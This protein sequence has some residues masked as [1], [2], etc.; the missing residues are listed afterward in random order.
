MIS[1]QNSKIL[2]PPPGR[3][4]LSCI[5][6]RQLHALVMRLQ[7]NTL[8]GGRGS[9]LLSRSLVCMLLSPNRLNIETV[10]ELINAPCVVWL[11]SRGPCVLSYIHE[12]SVLIPWHVFGLP[13]LSSPLVSLFIWILISCWIITVATGVLWF[14]FIINIQHPHNS[15]WSAIQEANT[16]AHNQTN[17]SVLCL[18]DS[19][20]VIISP[21][22]SAEQQLVLTF[23]LLISGREKKKKGNRTNRVGRITRC[24]NI[25][26]PA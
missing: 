14:F 21:Q 4:F 2:P 11:L 13:L 25:T 10:S 15:S 24:V 16:S 1:F 26:L 23:V 17:Y 3:W 8:S 9:V 20:L 5:P 6:V 22:W 12:M 18:F 7:V 19:S